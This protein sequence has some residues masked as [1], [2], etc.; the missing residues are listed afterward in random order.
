MPGVLGESSLKLL[1][2]FDRGNFGETSQH[3][4]ISAVFLILFDIPPALLFLVLF[5]TA[6]DK[7]NAISFEGQRND[8]ASV[9]SKIS[10]QP[11]TIQASYPAMLGLLSKNH[12]K[13]VP[14]Q[15]LNIHTTYRQ[16][17]IARAVPTP[18]VGAI[19]INFGPLA[20]YTGCGNR[21]AAP[22]IIGVAIRAGL[23][24]FLSTQRQSFGKGNI[25]T[26]IVPIFTLIT[27]H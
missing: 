4:E 24:N 8:F 23:R 25:A 5:I 12:S 1:F 10:C 18:I 26:K 21:P 22:T 16:R 9:Y 17:N 13:E 19:V 3:N 7:D 2:E 6:G 14:L 15:I 20:V 11:R 27:R